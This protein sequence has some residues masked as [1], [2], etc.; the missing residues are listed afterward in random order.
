MSRT[1]AHPALMETD[2]A[3]IARVVATDD[4][5]AFELLVRRH[6][7]PLRNFLRRLTR[8]D[9]ARADDLAQET[10]LRAY[11]ALGDFRGDA[12]FRSWLF[13]IAYRG[14]LND[15]RARHTHTEFDETVHSPVMDGTTYRD[16]LSDIQRAL[17]KLTL[18]QQAVFDLHYRKG[19]AHGEI[20]LALQVPIGTV[21]SDLTRGCMRLRQLLDL[22]ERD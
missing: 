1:S 21:K 15:E 10:F 5:A 9:A 12:S 22:L 3:L 17:T 20:A 6:Q 18:R 14:F 7:S 4:R 19:M 11:R 13:R 16:D 8:E 2:L